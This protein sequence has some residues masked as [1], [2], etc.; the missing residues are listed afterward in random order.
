MM[1]HLTRMA[2][3]SF[4]SIGRVASLARRFSS[5]RG[6]SQGRLFEPSWKLGSDFFA[7]TWGQMTRPVAETMRDLMLSNLDSV[8]VP[9]KKGVFTIADY[10]TSDGYAS[11][12]LFTTMILSCVSFPLYILNNEEKLRA[13]HGKELAIQVIYED[14]ERN[15]FNALF[16]RLYDQESYLFQFNNVYP[17]A[18]NTNFYKQCVPDG[19]C[20]V[21]FCNAGAHYL[22]D[23]EVKF[24]DAI[25]HFSPSVTEEELR[26]FRK[27]AASQWED[28]LVLRARELKPGGLLVVMSLSSHDDYRQLVLNPDANKDE[29]DVIKNQAVTA[30]RLF[31]DVE[32]AWRELRGR[33]LITEEE[34]KN[35]QMSLVFRG[36]GEITKPFHEVNSLVL[37]SGLSLEFHDQHFH[38]DPW[39]T[40][41]CSLQRQGGVSVPYDEYV[42]MMFRAVSSVSIHGNLSRMRSEEDKQ[43]IVEQY[44]EIFRQ[45]V[46]SAHPDSYVNDHICS[47]LVARKTM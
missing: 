30:Y 8:P 44:Y 28:F 39:K 47:R 15:D 23:P 38:P 32:Q 12:P 21:I 33:N 41:W 16:N 7:K 37:Q 19:T 25:V 2:R 29:S 22:R 27:E 36:A 5:G 45:K 34:Y 20:D 40:S 3:K 43:A 6:Q 4:P 46:A 10:G 14:Q 17:M 35:Y 9:S 42:T 1:S 31:V 24:A 26:A 11:M 13:K 18:T